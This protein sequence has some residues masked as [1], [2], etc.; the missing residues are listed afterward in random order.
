MKPYWLFYMDTEEWQSAFFEIERAET[1][2][3]LKEATKHLLE[4]YSDFMENLLGDD[5]RW[6][7]EDI[8]VF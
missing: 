6:A 7:Q 4:G 1:E 2:E 8:L 5:G 3:E